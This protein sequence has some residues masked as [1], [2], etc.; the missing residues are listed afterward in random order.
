LFFKTDRRFYLIFALFLPLIRTLFLYPLQ[1]ILLANEGSG[2]FYYLVYYLSEIIALSSTFAL[3]AYSFY[4]LFL[5]I[6][7]AAGL[8]LAFEGISL[9]GFGFLLQNV[10]LWL[11]TLL[12]E[13]LP[14]LPFYLSNYTLSQLESGTL[15]EAAVNSFLNILAIYLL[16]LIALLLAQVVKNKYRKK[17]IAITPL[18][19]SYSDHDVNP[20]VKVSALSAILYFG[21]SL[22]MSAIE[23]VMTIQNYGSP[24][25]F[26]DWIY[27]IAPHLSNL[28]FA[29]L[30][31]ELTLW[32]T[33]K[34]ALRD[35]NSSAAKKEGKQ[36]KETLPIQTS[37]A[38]QTGRR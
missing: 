32:I 35:L 33:R 25:T 36:V 30:C 20:L 38:F 29:V 15:A 12:D 31:F 17:K 28:V 6:P 23:T 22:L 4:A 14:S 5:S 10:L 24:V 2:I 11:G 19:L 27:L 13:L 37:H 1:N 34:L 18:M 7:G 8:G 21:I 3:L 9:L 16:F 26:S